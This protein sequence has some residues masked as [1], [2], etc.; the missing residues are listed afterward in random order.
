MNLGIFRARAAFVAALLFV[1]AQSA[2]IAQTLLQKAAVSETDAFLPDAAQMIVPADIGEII[3]HPQGR[4]AL[5]EQETTP[6][7]DETQTKEG[8]ATLLL[9]DAKLRKT[10]IL[11][12]PLP[13]GKRHELSRIQWLAQTN[14][15]LIVVLDWPSPPE[16]EEK[17]QRDAVQTLLFFNLDKSLAPRV[18]VATSKGHFALNVS[19]TKPL[20]SVQDDKNLRVGSAPSGAFITTLQTIIAAFMFTI[21]VLTEL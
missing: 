11:W 17:T 14:W 2:G 10:R 13:D 16:G 18:L 9:Y 6:P 20:F 7:S 5:I 3:L 1:W 8:A 21:G 15:F 4:Y 19:R 12:K